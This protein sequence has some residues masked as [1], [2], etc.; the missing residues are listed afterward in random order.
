M[1]QALWTIDEIVAA[2]GGSLEGEP[3]DVS[4]VSIDSRTVAPGD[5]FIAIKGDSFDGHDFVAA[6]LEA[7]ASAALVSD[8]KASDIET[9][10]GGLV[11]VP[12]AYDGMVA[13][14][15]AARERTKARILAITGS[16][17]KTSTKETFRL[18]L[19]G[20]GV[21]HAPVKSFNN[22]WGVPLTLCRMPRD[23]DFGVF[24][25]GM[26]ARGEI[27]PLSRLV[28][29]DLAMIT[30][31]AAVHLENLGSLEAIARE[32]SDIFEGFENGGIAVLHGDLDLSQLLIDRAKGC[33]ADQVLTFGHGAGLDAELLQVALLPHCSSVN[34]RITGR[35]L[36]YK[37]G[38]PGEHLVINSLG[39]LAA[40]SAL[41]ID[42][43]RAGMALASMKQ[44][45]GRGRQHILDTAGDPI[46]LLDESYNA[47]PASVEAALMVLSRMP[48]GPRGRR[49]AV[50]GD[51]LELGEQAEAMHAGL[52][53]ALVAAKVDK[54][55]ASGSLMRALWRVVPL[56]MRGHYG[57][58]AHEL[59]QPMLDDLTPGDAV[60]VKGSLGSKMG[61]LVEKIID[62][63][64]SAER[65]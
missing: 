21:T 38:A 43:A 35:E 45:E 31:V 15:R 9:P 65:A 50:L 64:S 49:I 52:A 1:V 46:T 26:N 39:V 22:H 48:V 47:N 53:Q 20:F 7:G 13:L 11:I 14:A 36:T 42:L 23:A 61:P 57:A 41:G 8:E 5:L 51:M 63:F 44:P 19:S 33:G 30:T 10:R 18:I 4:G 37:V 56:D 24:E 60:M 29:P 59:A 55:F 6:A 17:G 62:R 16:V 28:R 12:D 3:S 27:A 25:I 54:V 40:C 32:K 34:A 2:T 58:S